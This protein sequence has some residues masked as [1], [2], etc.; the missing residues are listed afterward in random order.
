MAQ[1]FTP[2]DEEAFAALPLKERDDLMRRVAA[3]IAING[4]SHGNKT[5]SA[6]QCADAIGVSVATV[7]AWAYRYKRAGWKALVDRRCLPRR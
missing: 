5:I 7:N 2:E 1:P 3:A 4:A 6:R